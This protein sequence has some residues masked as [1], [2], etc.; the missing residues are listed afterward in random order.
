[1][2]GQVSQ[3]DLIAH[4]QDLRAAICAL[5]NALGKQPQLD[6][7]KLREDFL[8]ACLAGYADNPRI[9][10][11]QPNDLSLLIAQSIQRGAVDA[12]K[13]QAGNPP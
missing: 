7:G 1:M 8:E 2:A 5:A 4:V 13:D 3:D 12:A 11:L 9:S 10:P 6:K